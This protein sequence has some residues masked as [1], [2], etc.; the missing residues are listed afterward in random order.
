MKVDMEFNF[1]KRKQNTADTNKT[2]KKKK[3]KLREWV[4]A[5]VFA[6]IA[7]TII[8]WALISAYTIP[9]SS[10]EGT[11]LVGDFLFVSKIAYGPR[12]PI[13]LLRM[14]LTDDKIWFTNIP[15]YLKWIQLPSVRL[16]G[17][18]SVKNG[19]IVVFNY[20]Q[21]SAYK[22]VDVK[23]HYIKRCVAIAG[24]KLEI[25]DGQ[26]YLNGKIFQNPPHVQFEYKL[27]LKPGKTINERTIEK[28]KLNDLY[29]IAEQSIHEDGDG[30]R[31]LTSPDK[32]KQ[33][34][35]ISIIHSVVKRNAPKGRFDGRVYPFHEKFPWNEDNFGPL[36]IPKKGMTI[37]IN[38]Q[39]LIQYK[40]V[41]EQ[42]EWNKKV[43]IKNNNQLWIDGK[44][45][46]KY[47]F[48]QDYFFMMGDNRHN[49]ADSRFWGFVPENHVVG[50]ASLTW[51]SLD[52]NKSF[53]SRVRWGRVFRWIR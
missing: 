39:N 42:Y 23:T 26:V 50:Q 46:K 33:L 22:P 49:S 40:M 15:S 14:P 35:K 43:E 10:M 18:T 8:R 9:T 13:T 2:P 53:F 51:L 30:Y 5:I 37:D 31:I 17:Y 44:E 29:N 38:E 6:V 7:A 41:I 47:T 4:D 3:S 27:T 25:K 34:A 28:Y 52:Y 1:L 48:K 32:A 20:P 12:T 21:D 19:H 24:D 36:V 11:E 45:V 16:P